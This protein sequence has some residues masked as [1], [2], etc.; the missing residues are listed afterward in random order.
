VRGLFVTFEGIDHSGK[1]TMA[2]AVSSRLE[3]LG[4]EVVRCHEPGGTN[5]SEAIRG[6]LLSRDST[7]MLPETELWLYEAARMQLVG[8]VI[9]PALERGA[10]VVC[11]RYTDSTIAYQCHARGLDR[12]LV[13]HANGIGSSGLAPDVTV[14]L[15]LPPAIAAGRAE[16]EED[17]IEAEGLGFQEAVRSGFLEIASA[18]PGRCTI[19]D[20]RLPFEEAEALAWEPIAQ[21]MQA[22]GNFRGIC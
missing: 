14:I 11:D 9:V 15:D 3:E 4:C 10:V 6:V 20:A 13:E 1:T 5:I 2:D 8:E 22:M 16:D 12:A 17:R 18:N 7:G 19:V 21:A